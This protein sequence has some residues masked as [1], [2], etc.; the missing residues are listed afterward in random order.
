MGRW[1]A[2]DCTVQVLAVG[3]SGIC[4]RNCCEELRVSGSWLCHQCFPA[5]HKVG[6]YGAFVTKYMNAIPTVTSYGNITVKEECYT[7][8]PDSFHIFRDPL[9]GDLPWP[10]LIFG[11]TIISLWYWCTDQ[12]PM[13]LDLGGE[14]VFPRVLQSLLPFVQLVGK[15]GQA[16][17]VWGLL[18]LG[19]MG[20][21][22]W[23]SG[24][25]VGAGVVRI[26]CRVSC[27][28]P[29]SL[30]FP[31]QV[32]V[33]RC[34]SAKNM[35][36]VKAGCI[37]CGYMKLLPMFLMVMPGMISRI[38]FTGDTFCWTRQQ[39]FPTLKTPMAPSSFF[40]PSSFLAM[41]TKHYCLPWPRHWV[42]WG[43]RACVIVFPGSLH[44]QLWFPL[45]Q[46]LWS[47]D[48]PLAKASSS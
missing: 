1:L 2:W 37:M 41:I 4:R 14:R 26:Y 47:H 19:D 42:T 25:V 40:L 45:L 39:L 21:P 30:G 16:P 6:G 32:I 18:S 20:V 5:F 48:M 23:W 27:L 3:F 44:R 12:V 34:L 10:G 8:R 24:V 9:K 17:V 11:L 22:G 7:P 13:L 28:H 35:S 31:G 33:Q 29:R 43:H 36:H 15:A 38:L 46:I